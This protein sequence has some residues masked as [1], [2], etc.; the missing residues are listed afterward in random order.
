MFEAGALPVLERVLAFTEARHGVLATNVANAE[1]P[2][3]R[4]QDLPVGAFRRELD[5]AVELRR[6]RPG[7]F[8]M[9]PV[10]LRPA[11]DD[12]GPF[13]FRRNHAGVL[14]HDGNN[15]DLDQEMALLGRN[16]LLHN[17]VATLLRQ[18]YGLLRTAVAGRG[19]GS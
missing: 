4:R 16:A 15:V 6:A 14:R 18:K 5:R 9:R 13:V 12:R 7:R 3:W 17:T 1:T 11:P 10:D 8:R 19:T 2:T